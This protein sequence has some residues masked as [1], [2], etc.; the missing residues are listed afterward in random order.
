MRRRIDTP[1]HHLQKETTVFFE[2]RHYQIRP[3][4]REKWV[5][6]MEEVIIPFQSSKGMVIVGSFIDLQDDNHYI[7]MRRFEDEA[8]RE[9]LYKAVYE[10]DAWNNEIK[11]LIDPLLIRETIKVVRLAPTPKSVIR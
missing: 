1:R 6:L 11:P 8:D 5:R 9:R 2:L 4:Q 10:T 7:W 3:G